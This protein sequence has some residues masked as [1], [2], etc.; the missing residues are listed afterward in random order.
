M[1]EFYIFLILGL[2]LVVYIT[3]QFLIS[4]DDKKGSTRSK[5]W[6]WIKDILDLI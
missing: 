5:I 4:L 2:A 3:L 6:N 1:V